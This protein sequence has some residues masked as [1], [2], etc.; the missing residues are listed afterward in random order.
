M[1][2]AHIAPPW[3]AVPP[4]NYGGTE[5]VIYNLI[6]EQVAQGH[7]VTLFAPGD[8]KTSARHIA[9]FSHSLGEDNVP[10][11]AHLKAYYHLHKSIAY[12]KKHKEDFDIVHTHL[13]SSSDMYLFPLTETLSIPQVTTLHSQFPFDK[14]TDGWQGDADHYYMEWLVKA[15]LIAISES[16]RQQ[17]QKKGFPLNIVGVIHH[18]IPVKSVPPPSLPLGNFFVWLGRMVPEK[19]AHLAIEAAKKAGVPLILA[20]I[21]DQHVPHA[22]RYFHE[23]IEP[24]IDGQQIK[25]IGPI[26]LQDKIDLLSR[27]RGLLNP[28]QWEEPFGM[29]MVEAM[30]TG[31]PVIAFRRGAAKEIITSDRVG[32]LVNDVVEMVDRIQRIDEIDR[33]I[34]RLYTEEHFSSRAMAEKYTRAYKQI[35]GR[36]SNL[37]VPLFSTP[38]ATIPLKT[39]DTHQLLQKETRLGSNLTLVGTGEQSE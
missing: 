12:L 6:E 13:S 17:E 33:K 31:C 22:K 30:A 24:Q 37:L 23:Q 19:G 18:G 39:I 4:K 28:I 11:D 32:F 9:F 29:V 14:T 16:A 7:V 36:R 25:Y 1:R 15:P 2:I 20:G 34:V 26:G 8:A 10:W 3:L 21:V 27:A 35:I 5:N 38:E